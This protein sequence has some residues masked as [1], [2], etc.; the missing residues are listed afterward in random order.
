MKSRPLSERFWEKVSV[1]MEG[2]WEWLGAHDRYGMI[3]F[4]SG[5]NNWLAHRVSWIIHNGPIPEGVCVLHKCDNTLCCRPDHL[6]LGTQLDNIHDRDKK[7]RGVQMYG[8]KHWKAK[9]SEKDVAEIRALQDILSTTE[10]SRN[11]GVT[12]GQIRFVQN[13]QSWKHVI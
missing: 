6:F 4:G 2:C 10:L 13:R 7:R 12:H 11:Y 8:E 1:Q 5:D 3:K 9:L